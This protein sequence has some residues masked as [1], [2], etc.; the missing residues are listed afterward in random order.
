M[1]QLSHYLDQLLFVAV[2]YVAL[3]LFFLGTIY[4]YRA[5]TFSYSSLSSQFLENRQHFWGMVPFH[6]G[7]LTVLAG[8]AIAFLVPSSILAWNTR[9]LRLY[10]LEVSALAFGVMTLVGFLAILARRRSNS[11]LLRVTSK[12]DWVLYALLLFQLASGV[13]VAVFH[14]W[15]S[16]WFATTASPY[17]WSLAKLSPQVDWVAAL[18]WAVKLHILNAWLLIGFF[19]FTRLV[20]ILVVPNPYLWRKRQVVRWNRDPRT[21]RLVQ[22]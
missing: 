6:Y 4:R 13:Y 22:R 2:P 3:V 12:A 14:P 5:E 20:H 8:H 21:A 16:A 19:P 1:T 9:P 7:I 18:P 17:L 10:I 11:K 15:G